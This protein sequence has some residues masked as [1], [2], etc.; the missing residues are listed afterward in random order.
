MSKLSKVIKANH[1][2]ISFPRLVECRRNF[3]EKAKKSDLEPAPPDSLSF[4]SETAQ[5][6][7]AETEELVQRLLNEARVHAEKIISDAKAK[8]QTILQE[9][10]EKIEA[11]KKETEKT[12][13]E[14]GFTAGQQALAEEWEKFY[15][16]RDSE[17]AAIKEERNRLIQQIEPELIELAVN[18][19]R[20]I[21]HAELHLAPE[22]IGAIAKAALAQVR[23]CGEV[24]LKI[25]S[26]DY[27][28][29]GELLKKEGQNGPTVKV[30]VENSL[31][32]G[33][34]IVETPYGMIDGTVEGQL[35]AVAHELLEVNQGG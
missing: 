33:G 4:D 9:A 8:A 7:V 25:R 3:P 13:Y 28:Y 27:E 6:I 18:I 30:E 24:T 16:E 10:D 11:L 34:C 23:D 5:A 14:A 20:Q 22:Q 31:P 29:V 21:I 26:N 2:V 35:D 12:G 17:R 15:A 19:A 1:F 32:N